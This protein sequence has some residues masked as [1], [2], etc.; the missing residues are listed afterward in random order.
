MATG[1]TLMV[2][3]GILI[4]LFILYYRE[5]HRSKMIPGVVFSSKKKARSETEVSKGIQINSLF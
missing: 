1:V 3:L 4:Y 2:V 5:R